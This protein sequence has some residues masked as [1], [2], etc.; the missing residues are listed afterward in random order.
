MV[1][2]AV[3][4]Y[5]HKSGVIDQV[6]F[7]PAENRLRHSFFVAFR[8]FSSVASVRHHHQYHERLKNMNRLR[9]VS[10]PPGR[11]TSCADKTM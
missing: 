8:G 4:G 5:S 9:K 6:V 7:C 2:F 11:C 3:C 1:Y 10:P